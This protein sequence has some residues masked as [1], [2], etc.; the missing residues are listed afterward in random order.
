MPR[1]CDNCYDHVARL[2]RS[3]AFVVLLGFLATTP[4]PATAAQA[5]TKDSSNDFLTFSGQIL[6]LLGALL[7]AGGGLR[8]FLA[9]SQGD[10][11]WPL[12]LLFRAATPSGGNSDN[13]G[14]RRRN[15]S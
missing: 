1:L 2:A 13:A 10:G 9:S 6:V 3:I 7:G 4:D 5:N 12:A 15:S 8:Y 11:D 14:E